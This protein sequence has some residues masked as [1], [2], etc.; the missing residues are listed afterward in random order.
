MSWPSKEADLG[1]PLVAWL[2]DRGADVYQEVDGH[3]GRADL[4]YKLGPVVGV[5]ELKCSFTLD[6][7]AQAAHWIPYAHLIWIAAPMRKRSRSSGL[8]TEVCDWKGIGVLE[9]L[10]PSPGSRADVRERIA[11]RLNRRIIPEGLRDQLRPEH[12]TF[13]AAGSNAGGHWTP[14]KQT[15]GRLLRVVTDAP[16]IALKDAVLQTQHHYA[17]N[18]GARSHLVHWIEAGKVPGVE[19]RRADGAL[20][21]FPL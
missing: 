2:T 13:A 10:G 16:G 12:K 15:C 19:L 20:R 4:A 6:V 14:F 18:A 11:P 1:P 8:L 7:V 3:G 9:V 5:V 21:L 17:S